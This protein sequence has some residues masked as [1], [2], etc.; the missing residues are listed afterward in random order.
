MKE[1]NRFGKKNYTGKP[2][3]T[4][5]AKAQKIPA[6]SRRTKQQFSMEDRILVVLK[7]RGNEPISINRLTAAAK[8]SSGEK[9]EFWDTLER[10]IANHTAVKNK[11]GVCLA[12]AA[13]VK[14]LPKAGRKVALKPIQAQIITLTEKFGFAK[15]VSDDPEAED[16]FLPGRMMMGAMPGDIVMVQP[17]VGRGSRMEGKVV[18]I[19]EENNEEFT[20]VMK[21][22]DGAWM[23]IPDKNIRFPLAVDYNQ[24]S[25]AK[26]GDKVLAQVCS[27]GSGHFSHRVK[28]NRVFGGADSAANCC[29]AVLSAYH[30]R[31]F[32]D[33]PTM[34]EARKVAQRGVPLKELENRLDLT[35]LDIFTIDSADS[36]DL[37][38]AVSLEK[39]EDHWELGV[40]IAD[41]S[42]Y[43]KPNSYL[44]KEAYQRAT[45]V[46]YADQVL[47]MLPKELSNGICSLNPDEVRLTFSAL[48][49]LNFQGQITGFRF[50]KTYIR[51]RVKGVYKEI[52]SILDNTASEE[53]LDKYRQLIPQIRLMKE[54]ADVLMKNRFER[55]AMDID[56]ME[57][58]FIIE[59]GKVQDIM[60]RE[61]GESERIIEEFMLTANQAAATLAMEQLLPFVYRVHANPPA[62]KV[63]VLHQMLLKIGM[64]A[65]AIESGLTAK[66]MSNVLEASRGTALEQMIN[67]QLLRTMAKAVY[68]EE[69]I[70]HFGLVLKNYAH[71][72]SPI[73]RYPDLII[74]RILSS[75]VGGSS[76]S[77]IAKRY[78]NYVGGAAKHCSDMEL[79]A[80]NIERDCEGCYKA[81]YM[82]CHI[83]EDFEGVI[84]TAASFG[85][86]VQLPNTV[87]GLVHVRTLP[88]GEYMLD[89]S[90]R[91]VE[92]RTNTS[93]G[94]GQKV[95]VTVAGADV[96]AGQVDFEL[97]QVLQ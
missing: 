65:S 68:S 17:E 61:R 88:Q 82:A 6:R 91:L 35:D 3:H 53:I 62:G 89:D 49:T 73:R 1:K 27:R 79:N 48:V 83:G 67:N 70:G 90:T 76:P 59:N 64:D 43:V 80:I 46:Y 34:E 11:N 29:Q 24:L 16:I 50:A 57:P 60:A 96:S 55:G 81:E 10:M 8:V 25:G 51:S 28:I 32:F 40:H 63:E 95:I 66:D 78:G 26:E 47:P 92:T 7:R 38:D 86:Y 12:S 93:Y 21:N 31:T 23:V 77:A 18:E 41:V 36:K 37:D 75:Y 19:L 2:K 69:N 14:A 33:E 9:P 85:F 74:H 20:G 4:P 54:L 22:Q 56:S 13:G 42:H 72:T 39:A 84:S 52:N 30:A 5:K 97:K 44:D 58:K 71:F 94:V 45:S 87:E 15:P